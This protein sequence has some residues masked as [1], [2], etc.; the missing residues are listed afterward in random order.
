MKQQEILKDL[1]YAL[2]K[3]A[4][5][6]KKLW[7]E[8]YLRHRIRYRGVITPKIKIILPAWRER[9]QLAS[10]PAQK[11][12]QLVT[13]L[14]RSEYAED[15]FAA[16]LYIELFL[17]PLLPAETIL[18]AVEKAFAQKLFYDWSTVDWLCMRVLAPLARRSPVAAQ[19]ILSWK[20]C[21]Y[22]WQAR[23]AIVPFAAVPFMKEYRNQ[24]LSACD[25][26]IRRPER[27]AKTAGGWF[28]R[29]L[30]KHD[31]AKVEEKLKEYQNHLTAEVIR[32][33]RKYSAKKVL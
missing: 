9:H 20:S 7:F 1:S 4:E 17:L 6:K 27:F 31:P 23:A 22:L 5:E 11:Q 2:G 33:A 32:N 28:L 25:I 13:R 29:V 24:A 10:L 16:T 19:R 30:S 14:W 8:Q 21:E 15:K 26:L 3:E 12:L 18:S